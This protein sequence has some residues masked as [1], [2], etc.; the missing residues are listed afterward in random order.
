MKIFISHAWEN[1]SFAKPLAEALRAAGHEVWFDEYEYKPG[2]SLLG[3]INEGLLEADY[4]VVVFSPE[5]FRKYWTKVELDGLVALEARNGKMVLPIWLNISSDEIAKV[6]PT[7]AGRY[8]VSA[9]KDMDRVVAE[10][11]SAIDG[12]ER[13]RV[14]S[15]SDAARARIQ[16]ISADRKT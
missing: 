13:Q 2:D 15:R 16:K 11:L 1:K 8:A 14:F 10:L 12:S 7:H 4:G 5:Y 3:K 9:E 6:M